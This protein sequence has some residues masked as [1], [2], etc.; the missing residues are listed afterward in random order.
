MTAKINLAK[1]SLFLSDKFDLAEPDIFRALNEFIEDSKPKSGEITIILKYSERS[2]AIIGDTK[3]IKDQ[4]QSLNG[5]KRKVATFS[6]LAFG[7]GFI[8]P[9]KYIEEI[10]TLLA[11]LDLKVREVSRE[12][13]E[14]EFSG[15]SLETPKTKVAV[16]QKESNPKVAEKSKA[17]IVTK[18]VEKV[19]KKVVASETKPVSKVTNAKSLPPRPLP[20][21]K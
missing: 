16:A 12:D 3:P 18:T 17:K 7:P 19:P 11:S 13:Y 14:V 9:C 5:E 4:L 21:K 2:N 1:L 10:R 20:K 15:K 8:S 6:N